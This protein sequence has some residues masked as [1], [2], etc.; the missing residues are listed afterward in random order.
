MGRRAADPAYY[1]DKM[2]DEASKE[3]VGPAGLGLNREAPM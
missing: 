2:C 1:I 3:V